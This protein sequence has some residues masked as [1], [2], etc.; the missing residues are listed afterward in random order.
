[1]SSKALSLRV[2]VIV[3][4]EPSRALRARDGSLFTYARTLKPK[5]L[6]DILTSQN[7]TETEPKWGPKKHEASPKW[8]WRNPKPA[9]NVDQKKPRCST[10]SFLLKRYKFQGVSNGA[11]SGLGF[12]GTH[13]WSPFWLLGLSEP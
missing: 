11:P 4:R 9:P 1:M 8:A 3:K 5:A 12:T 7:S 2:L 6:E 10:P 13:F